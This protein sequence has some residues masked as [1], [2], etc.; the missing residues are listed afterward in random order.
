MLAELLTAKGDRDH[1]LQ[2]REGIAGAPA[3]DGKGGA[4]AASADK[5]VAEALRSLKARKL[6]K[7]GFAL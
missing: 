1:H 6:A 5:K 3:H 7:R 4:R 2:R